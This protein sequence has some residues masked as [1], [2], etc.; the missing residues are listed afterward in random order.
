MK[1]IDVLRELFDSKVIS[2]VNV[3]LEYPERH[4]SL[5]EVSNLAKVHIATTF[6][7][8]N[9]LMEKEFIRIVLMGKS[10]FY[11]LKRGEK[12]MI[13]FR[14]LKKEGDQLSTF[15][16]QI[17]D[18]TRVKKVI[19]ET[20]G[21][22]FAKLLLVGNFLPTDKIKDIAKDIKDKQNFWIDFV[23]ITEK[24]FDDMERLNIYDL[25]KKIIWERPNE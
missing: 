6:R 7:V 1:E 16:D 4:F 5:S 9:K 11:Q 25:N 3:F 12:S 10:K 18:K 19:L 15:V 8:L 13:L 2:V 21:S 14:F 17:K 20:K 22:N 24:Q 23:E